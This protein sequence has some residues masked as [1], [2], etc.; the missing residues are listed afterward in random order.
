[1]GPGGR[2]IYT[3]MT[4]GSRELWML[5]E[6]GRPQQITTGADLGF[7][8]TPS[9]CPDGHSVVYGSGPLGNAN[10]WQL[11]IETGKPRPVTAGGTHGGPSCGPEGK[12]VYFN[13]LGKGAYSLWRAPLAGGA[14]EQLTQFPSTYPVVSPDGKRVAY[15]AR[16]GNRAAIGII[17]ANGGA[18][19]STFEASL[20]GP[21]G[22]TAVIRWSP[23]GDALDYI[24]T[25]NGVSNVW[26]HPLAGGSPFAVTDFKSGL[27]FNFV[28]LAN[29]TDLVVARGGTTSDAV[30]IRRFGRE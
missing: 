6:G 18:A 21:P 3:S 7:F 26:R 28:W 15:L 24:D 12:W 11:D 29:G 5:A 8:S 22:G 19:E 14:P 4:G 27:L 20:S 25:Q 10:I 13:S 1:L 23:K 9:A 30:R 17:P 16:E 2:L